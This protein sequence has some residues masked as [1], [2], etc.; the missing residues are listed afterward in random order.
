[1]G[2][3]NQANAQVLAKDTQYQSV[4]KEKTIAALA[5]NQAT[6]N[7]FSDATFKSFTDNLTSSK[8][9]IFSKQELINLV[10]RVDDTKFIIKLNG[11]EYSMDKTVVKEATST[12][13]TSANAVVTAKDNKLP[14]PSV[15]ATTSAAPTT[16]TK[17]P[18]VDPIL[19]IDSINKTSTELMSLLNLNT[20]EYKFVATMK[21]STGIVVGIEFI[22]TDYKMPEVAKDNDTTTPNT[23]ETAPVT[24]GE[25]EKKVE[26]SVNTPVITPAPDAVTGVNPDEPTS[27]ETNT[28]ANDTTTK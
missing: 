20:T 27:S 13:A 9:K 4:L 28:V 21:D 8:D 17:N 2:K 6:I 25:I 15:D 10:K 1:M 18:A 26:N 16:D 24:G 3:V 12:S 14:T 11:V 22:G 5:L 23:K 19:T 7:M